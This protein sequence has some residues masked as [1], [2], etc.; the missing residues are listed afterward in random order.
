MTEIEIRDKLFLFGKLNVFDQQY[1]LGKLSDMMYKVSE[2]MKSTTDSQELFYIMQKGFADIGR[3][4]FKELALLLLSKV[5]YRAKV[6][7]GVSHVDTPIVTGN[8]FQ[9]DWVENDFG[10]FQDLVAQSIKENFTNF[11]ATPNA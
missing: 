5:K 6:S 11:L 4:E 3:A 1:V 2:R 8:S 9:F 10:L 7:D